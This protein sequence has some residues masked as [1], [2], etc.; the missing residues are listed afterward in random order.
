MKYRFMETY[1]SQFRV[2][3]MAQALQLTRSG[4]YAWLKR[5][6]SVRKRADQALLERIKRVYYGSK[7]IYGSPRVTQQLHR[8]GIGCGK[9]RVARLMRQNQL[10]SRKH[11]TYKVT[12][13]SK[14]AY[15]VA[16]NLLNQN[17]VAKQPNTIWLSDISYIATDEGWLYLAGIKDL[18]TQKIVGWSMDKTM[19]KN[20]VMQAL[21]MALSRQ[22]PVEGLILHSDRGV[23]YAC[24]A[25][26][27]LLKKHGIRCSMS[28]SGNPYD[29]A[30]M[31]SFFSTLKTEW[32]YH[33]QYKTRS[34]AKSS[35]F[36][37]IERFYNPHRLN[38]SIGY[39][40]PCEF[41][42]D[43]LSALSSVHFSG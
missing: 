4:F 37:Y 27:L 35:I 3:K 43:Y 30:P 32:V 12:T 34:E 16:Y 28:R 33:H 18:Y 2:K 23:Q 24:D 40:T 21:E 9:N 38:S 1:R 7:S 17:F 22:K 14:H 5:K 20:L 25:Y 19:T 29:N 8:E 26:Q 10:Q 39:R 15:P 13:Q 42:F 31:E 6:D 11:R 36:E 41:E